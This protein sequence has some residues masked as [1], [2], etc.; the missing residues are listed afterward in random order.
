MPRFVH[1]AVKQCCTKDGNGIINEERLLEAWWHEVG[2]VHGRRVRFEG[3]ATIF[4]FMCPIHYHSLIRISWLMQFQGRILYIFIC[5]SK[6]SK[7]TYVYVYT[8][9]YIMFMYAH[10]VPQGTCVKHGYCNTARLNGKMSPALVPRGCSC[11]GPRPVLP[12]RPHAYDCS[13]RTCYFFG[14]THIFLSSFTSMFLLLPLFF[15][16]SFLFSIFLC[17]FPSD[18]R[19][20]CVKRGWAKTVRSWSHHNRILPVAFRATACFPLVLPFRFERPWKD[21]VVT[22]FQENHCWVVKVKR[23]RWRKITWRLQSSKEINAKAV[24]CSTAMCHC[25]L[26]YSN[27]KDDVGTM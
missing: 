27:T 23:K 20:R 12:P 16:C 17:F 24:R 11:N 25:V 8:F 22:W 7:N 21:V 10:S 4:T 19:V 15:S 18:G 5:I 14:K 26:T 3:F 2:A 6:V 13:I 1:P 9:I